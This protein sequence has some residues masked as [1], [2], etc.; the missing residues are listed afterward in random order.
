MDQVPQSHLDLIQSRL[1]AHGATA[2]AMVGGF[3]RNEGLLLDGKP[4]NDYDILTVGINPKRLRSIADG[5]RITLGVRFVDLC[6]FRGVRGRSNQQFWIDCRHRKVIFG[7]VES[8]GSIGKPIH[9]RIPVPCDLH[10]QLRNRLVTF[11]D[12]WNESPEVACYQMCKV[13]IACLDWLCANQGMGYSTLIAEKKLPESSA[14][15]LMAQCCDMRLMRASLIHDRATAMQMGQEIAFLFRQ[16]LMDSKAVD[17]LEGIDRDLA[18]S[19]NEF[20][21]EKQLREDR[22]AAWFTRY[23]G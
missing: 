17:D 7:S 8:F 15:R 20:P 14:S 1:T 19:V 22:V 2:A 21:G 12:P 16:C 13:G 9:P 6:A 23:L 11:N 18:K 5:I 3:G 10:N 4:V